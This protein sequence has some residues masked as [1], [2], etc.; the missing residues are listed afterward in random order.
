MLQ[1]LIKKTVLVKVPKGNEWHIQIR[2]IQAEVL[3]KGSII[4]IWT[5]WRGTVME[6]LTE[7]HEF[8]K[9]SE[10]RKGERDIQRRL[11]QRNWDVFL[12]GTHELL[13]GINFLTSFPAPGLL[14]EFSYWQESYGAQGAVRIIHSDQTPKSENRQEGGRKWIGG[15]KGDLCTHADAIQIQNLFVLIIIFTYGNRCLQIRVVAL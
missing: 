6:P 10:T 3:N 12:R 9:V 4:K 1:L 13:F 8:G 7:N 14:S 2:I 15:A 11:P 5:G